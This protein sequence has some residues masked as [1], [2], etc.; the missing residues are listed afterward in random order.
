MVVTDLHGDLNL[1]RRYRDRFLSLHA[2][3][4]AQTLVFCGDLIHSD[5]PARADGSLAIMLDLLA[6]KE[7]LGS[8]LIVLLGNHELPHIYGV[9]LARGDLE[10]TPRFEAAMGAHREAILA[11]LRSLPFYLR[12]QAG[13]LIS[14]AG[15]PPTVLLPGDWERI[16]AFDH[17]A[18]LAEAGARIQA[19]D[20]ETLAGLRK[21]YARLA[22][23]S[24]DE[25]ARHYLAVAGGD[26]PRYNDLLRSLLVSDMP[27]F[28]FLWSTLFTR[29]ELDVGEER[30]RQV[31]DS[32]L[33]VASA[34]FVEQRILVAGHIPTRG[35]VIVA[36]RHLRLHSGTFNGSTRDSSYLLLDVAK[37]V[38]DALELLSRIYRIEET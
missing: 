38:R 24:Y 5:G 6:L 17:D 30:Y 4:F 3:G 37:P 14:H 34:G 33:R 2:W 18:L 21:S 16:C 28:N 12:T 26:D 25:L 1:Y 9:N 31:V 7:R 29:N 32:F 27:D 22:G 15:A 23:A 36:G 35:R 10:Y 8:S 13:V 11:L 20:P 19:A